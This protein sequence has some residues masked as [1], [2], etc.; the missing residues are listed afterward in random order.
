LLML[1][2][3][4]LNGKTY[5]ELSDLLGITPD[6]VKK[7][8]SRTYDDLREKISKKIGIGITLFWVF[9]VILENWIR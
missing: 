1:K 2:E 9:F 6:G 8:V 4:F 7:M 5:K 3:K